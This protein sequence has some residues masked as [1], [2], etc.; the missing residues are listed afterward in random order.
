MIPI[1][2]HAVDR[3]IERVLGLDVQSIDAE[4]R[5][6]IVKGMIPDDIAKRIQVL[7]DGDYP[8]DGYRLRVIDGSV[9]TVIIWEK[10]R[11]WALLNAD[12]KRVRPAQSGGKLRV[13]RISN[14]RK[15]DD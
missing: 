2:N 10:S 8:C 1:T 13:R 6:L 5:R 4:G 3:F 15:R 7:G 14:E 9:V 11:K 12:K